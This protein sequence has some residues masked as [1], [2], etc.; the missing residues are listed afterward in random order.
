MNYLAHWVGSIALVLILGCGGGEMSPTGGAG[1]S[2]G[3]EG[4]GGGGGIGGAPQ[5]SFCET[6]CMSPCLATI[7]ASDPD[8]LSPGDNCLPECEA[9]IS[10]RCQEAGTLLVS[11]LESESCL[12]GAE[13]L[14]PFF[15]F[16]ECVS[17]MGDAE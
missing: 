5:A 7:E 15:V 4:L 9:T 17:F 10:P 12:D 8:V 16:S 2:A 11:C 1:G 14:D 3:D 13:C 6:A